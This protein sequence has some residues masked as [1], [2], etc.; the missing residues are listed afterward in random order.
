M[1]TS[2]KF[3][4]KK[5]SII[6]LLAAFVI[7][8][9]GLREASTII[10]PV[11]LSVFIAIISSPALFWLES[12]KSSKNS[13]LYNSSCFCYCSTNCHWFDYKFFCL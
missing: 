7:V 2:K 6:V 11:L 13:C 3:S 1:P 10:V 4:E 12:K 5:E 9:A 8:A